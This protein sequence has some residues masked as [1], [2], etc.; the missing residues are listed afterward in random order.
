MS[1]RYDTISFLSDYGHA[2]EFVGVVHSVIR[3]IA[4]A[5][6]VIDLVHG[7]EPYDV[8]GASLALSRVVQYVAPGIVLAVVDPGVGTDRRALAVEVGADGEG[9]LIG[10]D[11]GLLAPAVAMSGGATR[12]VE[13]TNPEYQLPAPGPSFAGRDVF[14]PAAAHLAA[15]VPITEFGPEV[16]PYTLRPG[17]LPLTREEDGGL[18]V[19]VLWVDH[20][21]NCQL[22]LDPA[23]V[24]GWGDPLVLRLPGDQVRRARRVTT[25]AE[26]GNGQV[27][28]MVDSYGLVAITVN[29]SSAAEIFALHPGAAVRVERNA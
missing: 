11:N 15:G 12:I 29:Q 21:G 10:P 24:E 26:V 1:R 18:A 16:D 4:P 27:G 13:L 7:L 19:E 20:F 25:Y 6:T 2:D 3:S 23:E 5:V 28:L 9:V 14:A 22:N 17:L 8:R